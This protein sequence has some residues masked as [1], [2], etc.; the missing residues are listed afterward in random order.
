MKIEDYIKQK[1]EMTDGK[2]SVLFFSLF[3]Y[4]QPN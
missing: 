2:K 1:G 3:C 4:D